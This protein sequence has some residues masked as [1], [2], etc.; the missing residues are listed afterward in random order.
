MTDLTALDNAPFSF[1]AITDAL[2][3]LGLA[4]PIQRIAE[5]LLLGYPQ[6]AAGVVLKYGKPDLGWRAL[7]EMAKTG[8]QA[9]FFAKRN[10]STC[11]VLDLYTIPYNTPAA[12]QGLIDAWLIVKP[13][14]EALRADGWLTI[15]EYL[16]LAEDQRPPVTYNSQRV[17]DVY[18]DPT[19]RS[20]T[21]PR[22]VIRFEGHGAGSKRPHALLKR[23]IPN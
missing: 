7:D 9:R 18:R 3:P 16:A 13:R 11:A 15:A 10:P 5:A 2:D 8:A 1:E 6:Y 22:Y 12:R 17:I 23:V 20:E 14:I 4:Q 19:Y 21:D